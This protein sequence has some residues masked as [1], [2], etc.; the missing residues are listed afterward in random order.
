MIFI[1]FVLLLVL[2]LIGGLFGVYVVKSIKDEND[3]IFYDDF[4]CNE[5]YEDDGVK[6][7]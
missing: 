6:Y 7:K 3:D 1:A 2:M 4:D 5:Y